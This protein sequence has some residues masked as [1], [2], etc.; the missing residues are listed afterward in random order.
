[1]ITRSWVA[2]SKSSMPYPRT[3]P[4]PTS[5]TQPI[6]NPIRIAASHPVTI[7]VPPPAL[8]NPQK[9]C[10]RSVP[11]RRLAP[12]PPPLPTRGLLAS[13][14]PS[15]SVQ[16]SPMRRIPRRP[17]AFPLS[18]TASLEKV[19]TSTRM[20]TSTSTTRSP[21]AASIRSTA[22]SRGSAASAALP[23]ASTPII[24]PRDTRELPTTPTM[25]WRPPH[26]SSST[27]R[28]E[29]TFHR[30]RRKRRPCDGSI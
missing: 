10:N 14:P 23:S 13:P 25:P 29:R 30:W 27:G 21:P 11:L 12:F 6:N 26:R 5:L 4:C 3:F 17:F 18:L 22:R 16:T 19:L 24:S 2:M 9:P 20:P 8:T 28:M 7:S 1:M 15:Q